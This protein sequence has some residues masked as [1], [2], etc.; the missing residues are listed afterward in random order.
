MI[1]Q[2]S[3]RGTQPVVN[4]HHDTEFRYPEGDGWEGKT[5]VIR[6]RCS[7]SWERL[8]HC[9]ITWD[10]HFVG[11]TISDVDLPNDVLPSMDPSDKMEYIL[12]FHC[13]QGKAYLL[14]SFYEEQNETEG[15]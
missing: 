3:G 1:Y 11:K 13:V 6:I 4:I 14:S 15:V 8:R 10:K 12:F 2:F 5:V 9:Q 7:D